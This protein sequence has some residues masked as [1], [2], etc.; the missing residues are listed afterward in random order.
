[1]P[2]SQPL[3]KMRFL[4]LVADEYEDLELWYPKLRL[5]EAGAAVTVAGPE[6]GK[7]YR[8]KHG[9]PCVSEAAIAEMEEMEVPQRAGPCRPEP[10]RHAPAL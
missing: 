10:G 3:D 6:R 2:T 9:Y 1:M 5:I 7:T 4:I 8:G